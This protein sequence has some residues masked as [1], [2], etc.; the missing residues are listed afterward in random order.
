MNRNALIIVVAT[1]LNGCN[2]GV[3]PAGEGEGEGPAAEGEGSEGEGEGE[4][5]CGNVDA[6]PVPVG[7]GTCATPFVVDYF[8]LKNGRLSSYDAT[9]PAGSS[10]LTGTGFCNDEQGKQQIWSYTAGCS[11]EAVTVR[12]GFPIGDDKNLD[13]YVRSTCTDSATQLACSAASG[14]DQATI[15]LD[16]LS[17]AFFFSQA[18]RPL[19]FDFAYGFELQRRAI[20]PR[21]DPCTP[22]DDNAACEPGIDVCAK[23]T[24]CTEGLE[25]L[26]ND[27]TTLTAGTFNIHP[28]APTN[29]ASCGTLPTAGGEEAF[30][31]TTGSQTADLVVTVFDSQGQAGV[32][33]RSLCAEPAGQQCIPSDPFSTQATFTSI[34]PNT[35][36]F[37]IVHVTHVITATLEEHPH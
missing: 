7:D 13:L 27:A 28:F 26:C 25:A 22:N 10:L 17:T 18:R 16:P 9:M 36:L 34:A 14:P 6:G 32:L 3:P 37:F 19:A 21:G 12:I 23:N 8:A 24:T 20:I 11:R 4:G 2:S 29:E 15:A 1:L 5:A 35:S 33:M 30:A 31:Y